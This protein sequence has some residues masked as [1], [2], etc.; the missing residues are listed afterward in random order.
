MSPNLEHQWH[1]RMFVQQ[2]L[3][4]GVILAIVQTIRF[5]THLLE[6]QKTQRKTVTIVMDM[7][8]S[9]QKMRMIGLRKTTA[10]CGMFLNLAKAVAQRFRKFYQVQAR[11]SDN[12]SF[13]V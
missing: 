1:H 5:V 12:V 11:V 9:K 6:P 13:L 10:L 7:E 4:Y 8:L 2:Q 3:C